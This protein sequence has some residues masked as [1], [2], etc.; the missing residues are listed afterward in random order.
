MN[1][2]FISSILESFSDILDGDF[3]IDDNFLFIE[4][5]LSN[6][7]NKSV[8]FKFD[9]EGKLIET[10]VKDFKEIY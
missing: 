4:K 7:E 9:H 8:L 3:L 6:E 1:I 10:R 2:K 5:Q